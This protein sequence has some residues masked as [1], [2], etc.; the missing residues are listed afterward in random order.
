MIQLNISKAR[1]LIKGIVQQVSTTDKPVVITS[2]DSP[3]VIVLPYDTYKDLVLNRPEY[4]VYMAI[5]FA[6]KFL[7]NAPRHM[8]KSQIKEFEKLTPLQ[9]CAFIKIESLPISSKKREA[10]IKVVGKSIV[11]R[12]EK[13]REI[14]DSIGKAKRDGIYELE[15]HKTGMQ[16]LS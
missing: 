3:S 4:S 15:E 5:M 12:L 9:L 8:I 11:E 2:G 14:A 13:R 7:F 1:D 16:E 6:R 10:L